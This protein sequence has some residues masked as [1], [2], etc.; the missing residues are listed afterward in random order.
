MGNRLSKAIK[1]NKQHKTS[2]LFLVN[3]RKKGS[4]FIVSNK[5]G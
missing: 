5:E 4:K 1:A 3:L 2:L